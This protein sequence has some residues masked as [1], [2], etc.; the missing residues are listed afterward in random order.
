MKK[1][2]LFKNCIHLPLIKGTDEQLIIEPLSPPELH[3]FLGITNKIFDTLN[4]RMGDNQIYKWAYKQCIVRVGYHGGCLE[5]NQA[6]AVLQH[7]DS[8][9]E[10]VPGHL[11]C[12]VLALRHFDN[13]RIACFGQK[14]DPSFEEAINDFK[15]VFKSLSIRITPKL[16]ILFDHVPQFCAMKRVGLGFFSEQASESVHA[17]FAKIW[18]RFSVP[19]HHERHGKNLLRA[20]QKYNSQ[21]L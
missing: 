16:H 9:Q 4:E 18:Q 17:D 12:F 8:L 15:T 5:G 11:Q 13:V 20:V 3:L 10:F 2:S 19:L 1:A 6:R 7:L 14:L 21:H